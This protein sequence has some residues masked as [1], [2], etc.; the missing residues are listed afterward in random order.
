MGL[1]ERLQKIAEDKGGTTAWDSMSMGAGR[2]SEPHIVN[3]ECI[4]GTVYLNCPK[5]PD[6]FHHFTATSNVQ[7]VERFDCDYCEKYFYD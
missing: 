4:N 6:G 2:K 1:E 3:G 5:S 7:S